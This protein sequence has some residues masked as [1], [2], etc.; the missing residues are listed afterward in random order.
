MVELHVNVNYE[1][2]TNYNYR[3]HSTLG[4]CIQNK[5]ME[6]EASYKVICGMIIIIYL[7]N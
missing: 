3:D 6:G 5:T 4:T 2:I 1:G 7:K